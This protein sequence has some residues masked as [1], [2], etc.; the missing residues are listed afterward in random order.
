M[1]TAIN[2]ELG[3]I[4]WKK[5]ELFKKHFFFWVV[6]GHIFNA[7]CR[8]LQL[9]SEKFDNR[10]FSSVTVLTSS[11]QSCNYVFLVNF[12]SYVV[13]AYQVLLC[14]ISVEDP[15]PIYRDNRNKT[16]QKCF[17]STIKHFWTWSKI[18]W[19]FKIIKIFSFFWKMK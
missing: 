17:R 9:L 7:A 13:L 15:E 12:R 4:N 8:H 6:T 11:L 19:H 2:L 16:N 1:V 10:V 3:G 18:V 14:I 5:L